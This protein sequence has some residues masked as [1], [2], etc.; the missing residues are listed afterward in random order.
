MKTTMLFNMVNSPNVR[1]AALTKKTLEAAR[2]YQLVRSVE[3]QADTNCEY[4]KE[5]QKLC[6]NSRVMHDALCECM[7]TL[8]QYCKDNQLSIVWTNEMEG[9]NLN[10]ET[11]GQW[12]ASINFPPDQ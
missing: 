5:F 6:Q 4:L 7:Q 10:R 9:T 12:A 2:R 11:I 3:V 1:L 8:L